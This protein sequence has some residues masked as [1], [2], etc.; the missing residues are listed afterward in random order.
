MALAADVQG[1]MSRYPD[2]RETGPVPNLAN[3]AK[4][5]ST[6]R[7]CGREGI[8]SSLRDLCVLSVAGERP[9]RKYHAE[10]AKALRAGVQYDYAGG[11]S[12]IPAP[13]RPQPGNVEVQ[14]GAVDGLSNPVAILCHLHACVVSFQRTAAAQHCLVKLGILPAVPVVSVN[15]IFDVT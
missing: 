4:S 8:L 15:S 5:Q 2:G 14:G 11:S 6:P 7:P 9:F 10:R 3:L 1:Q 13:L 12:R